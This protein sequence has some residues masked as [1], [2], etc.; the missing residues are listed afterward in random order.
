MRHLA[1]SF[2]G[3]LAG[4]LLFGAPPPARAA[5]PT[6][7]VSV[8]NSHNTANAD[9]DLRRDIASKKW[10]VVV[11]QEQSDAALPVGRGANANLPQFGA[12]ADADLGCERQ[13]PMMAYRKQVR[14]RAG[15]ACRR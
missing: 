3:Q 11:L 1:T 12:C 7:I 8:G 4:M 5:E 10:D 9:W 14:G 2:A 15:P 13:L 6:R